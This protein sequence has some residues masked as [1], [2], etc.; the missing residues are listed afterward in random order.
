[1]LSRYRGR[2]TCTSCQGKRLRKETQY[3]KICGKSINDL[4]DMPVD[5]LLQFIQTLQLSTYEQQ[6]AERLLIEINSRLDFLCEVGLSY[7][8]LNRKS[9]SLSEENLNELTW[10]PH[11][12]VAWWA[13]CTS[14]TSQVL[15]CIQKIPNA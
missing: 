12:A 10:Q 13:Q 15:V 4:I 2:T 11:L 5:E 9:N 1:M 7:L 14:S 8:T 6:I 3:V